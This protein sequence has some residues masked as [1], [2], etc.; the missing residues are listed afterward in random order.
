MA[1]R[2][3]V[4]APQGGCVDQGLLSKLPSRGFSWFL[5]TLEILEFIVSERGLFLKLC[6]MGPWF[7]Y[8]RV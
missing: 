4:G 7:S 2:D 5:W 8:F 6:L 3:L 1:M